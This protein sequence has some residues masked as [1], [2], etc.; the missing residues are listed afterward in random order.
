M[1]FSTTQVPVAVVGDAWSP[2]GAGRRLVLPKGRHRAPRRH[3][4]ALALHI[5]GITLPFPRPNFKFEVGL[6]I[7]QSPVPFRNHSSRVLCTAWVLL[8]KPIIVARMGVVLH[9]DLLAAGWML[10]RG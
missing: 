2:Q 10:V 3:H 6:S 4:S 7:R 8:V 9:M 5:S 1:P